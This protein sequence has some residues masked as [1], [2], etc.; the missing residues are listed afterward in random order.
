MMVYARHTLTISEYSKRA[1]FAAFQLNDVQ[2]IQGLDW[3]QCVDDFGFNIAQTKTTVIFAAN[4]KAFVVVRQNERMMLAAS[5][6][7]DIRE[8]G[9]LWREECILILI[10][11]LDLLFIDAQLMIV[12]QAECK[13]STRCTLADECAAKRNVRNS[14]LVF[15]N[16]FR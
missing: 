1:A 7:L 5:N 15:L 8:T 3:R 6:R 16:S 2:F 12:V 9:Q 10:L 14:R 11:F 4:C 13:N